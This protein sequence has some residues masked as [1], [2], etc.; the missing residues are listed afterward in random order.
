MLPYQRRI[1]TGLRTRC[2][3]V[4]EVTNVHEWACTL[5]Q[6]HKLVAASDSVVWLINKAISLVM[7]AYG[8]CNSVVCVGPVLLSQDVSL[9]SDVTTN[10]PKFI[11][12]WHIGAN[13]SRFPRFFRPHGG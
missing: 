6:H 13:Y 3:S 5:E 4:D 9:Y 12:K 2:K 7:E 11:S 8:G 1:N 10:N